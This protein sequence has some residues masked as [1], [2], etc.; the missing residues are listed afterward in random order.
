MPETIRRRNRVVRPNRWISALLI[1]LAWL[2]V[3]ALAVRKLRQEDR[4]IVAL[5]GFGAAAATFGIVAWAERARWRDPIQRLTRLVHA[6]RRRRKLGPIAASS[7]EFAELTK[8]I[9]GLAKR[10]RNRNR[11]TGTRC[12]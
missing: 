2:V 12:R 7:S 8:E 4:L 6:S 10:V 3:V 11:H 1:V 5:S 9:D